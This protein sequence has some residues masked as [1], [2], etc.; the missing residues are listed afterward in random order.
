MESNRC[1]GC[2]CE[3]CKACCVNEFLEYK[4]PG[5]VPVK[6]KKEAVCKRIG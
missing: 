2:V 6:I 4:C 3:G 1:K 5:F